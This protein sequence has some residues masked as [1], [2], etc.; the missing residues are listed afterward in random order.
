MIWT[1]VIPIPQSHMF[2]CLVPT[3]WS[4]TGLGGTALLEETFPEVWFEVTKSARYF[5]IVLSVPL[6]MLLDKK[7]VLSQCSSAMPE[8]GK[9]QGPYQL[10]LCN[11]YLEREYRFLNV[12][13]LGISVTF[14][15]RPHAQNFLV[16]KKWFFW[17]SFTFVLIYFSQV[18]IFCL[19]CLSVLAFSLGVCFFLEFCLFC[20]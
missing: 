14:Q 13:S 9:T 20:V 17:C 15:G 7:Y 1:R 8:K 11:I 10:P 5:Q 4:V 18:I 19:F 12:K 2:D 6:L 3:W 16:N